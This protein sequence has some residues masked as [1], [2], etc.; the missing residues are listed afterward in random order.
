GDQARKLDIPVVEASTDQLKDWKFF[1]GLCADLGLV[2]RDTAAPK[3]AEI[4]A[5]RVNRRGKNL[6]KLPLLPL[7]WQEERV[8][9]A[10]GNEGATLKPIV[11]GRYAFKSNE[12]LA[13]R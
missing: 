2:V 9:R 10:L 4:V 5:Q 1:T 11:E 8:W 13:T 7:R 12:R 3:H 6:P